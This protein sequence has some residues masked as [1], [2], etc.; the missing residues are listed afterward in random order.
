MKWRKLPLSLLIIVV[1]KEEFFAISNSK[2][3]FVNL[4]RTYVDLF[5]KVMTK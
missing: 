5:E 4:H 3:M 1:E 2:I